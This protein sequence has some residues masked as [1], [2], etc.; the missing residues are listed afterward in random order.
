MKYFSNTRLHYKLLMLADKE[1]KT[2]GEILVTKDI[3]MEISSSYIN[4]DL[5]EGWMLPN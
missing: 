5:P 4:E 1:A 3:S 2:L